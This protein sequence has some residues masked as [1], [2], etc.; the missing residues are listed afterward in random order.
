MTNGEQAPHDPVTKHPRP[1]FPQQEQ[2]VPGWTGAMDPPPDHGEESYR[3]HGLLTD[4]KALVTGGDSGIGRAVALAYAREGADVLFSHLESEEEDARETVRLIED[5][6]RRAVAVV[7]DVRE[8]RQCAGLVDRA[9]AEFGHI[10]ILV[11]NAAYQMSQPDGIGAI[12]TEQFDRVVRTNLYGMFWLSKLALPHMPKGGSIINSAS[13]QAYKPSPHLLDYAMTKGAIVTFTQGLA[14]TVAQDGI[15]V[16]AVAPGPVW[17]PLIPAT[18]PDTAEF[19][20]Q[21][22]L[23][24]PAQPAEMA[25]CYVFLAS[26]QASYITA[27]VLNATGGT[28]L[29]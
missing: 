16:N 11:N 12:S 4:R 10:D 26:P 6:G 9:V 13:V 15:R 1:E 21:S 5:A 2:A 22:P 28:P 7:C 24:R 23:G 18:L 27:E 19:G 29:P 20:K 14:Q 17:T 3:G 25:P 8:E